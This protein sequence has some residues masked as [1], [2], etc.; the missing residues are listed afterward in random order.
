MNIEYLETGIINRDIFFCPPNFAYLKKN[1][2]YEYLKNGLIS[3][4]KIIFKKPVIS[5]SIGV[6]YNGRQISFCALT[7]FDDL[8]C[9]E[10]NE[11]EM[12]INFF[13]H[14]F[15]FLFIINSGYNNFLNINVGIDYCYFKIIY[16][17]LEHTEIN[18][19]AIITLNNK[20]IK[21]VDFVGGF[22][23][24]V[25]ITNYD[26][27]NE[28]ILNGQPCY[29]IFIISPTLIYVSFN[30]VNYDQ[31]KNHVFIE[32][33]E[34][35][36]FEKSMSIQIKQYFLKCY[37]TYISSELSLSTVNNCV[38]LYSV[39]SDLDIIEDKWTE[40]F[41]LPYIRNGKLLIMKQSI[42]F[43]QLNP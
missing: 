19:N 15:G 37:E 16:R 20:N 43:Y 32:S 4:D 1:C 17:L 42:N 30:G 40:E 23:F 13:P 21:N 10:E 31:D 27:I 3:I 2:Y 36:T 7:L 28:I 11:E 14:I 9:T 29:D 24:G 38:A 34:I 33:F 41:S 39:K 8:G 6:Y 18:N 35:R 5:T 22:Y 12:T 25:F 26:V